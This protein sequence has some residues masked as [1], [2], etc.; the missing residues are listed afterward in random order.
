M[1]KI[2]VSF[3]IASLIISSNA[4]INFEGTIKW[5]LSLN[6]SKNT[7]TT[8]QKELT[9][10]QKAD[11][12]KGIAELES[13]LNDPGMQAMFESNPSMKAMLEQQLATMKTMQGE[14]GM[15]GLMPKSYTVKMKDGN[16]YTQM[17]GGAMAAA[18]DILYLKSTDKTYYIKKAAKTYSVAP[19]SKSTT[20]EDATTTVTAT[21]ETTK[22][23]NYTCTKY[24]V[25]FTEAGKTKTLFIWATKDLKQY[26]S[27]SFHTSGI[28]NQG[29]MTA[30]K[31]IDGVPLKIEVTEQGQ[32]IVLEVIELK[33]VTLSAADFVLPADYKEVPFGQ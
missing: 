9:P 5:S 3:F 19:K 8:T 17:E 10:Q 7:G 11:L 28:G 2:I 12:T 6:S 29:N 1:K 30:L 32:T 31:K 24:I 18:G 22:I 23:L 33:N 4:Q 21:T 13:K 14:N 27:G 16:S 15:N 20:S 25:T 26:A